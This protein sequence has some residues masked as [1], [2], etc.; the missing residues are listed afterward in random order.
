[1]MI[2]LTWHTRLVSSGKRRWGDSNFLPDFGCGG[3]VVKNDSK[4]HFPEISM[5]QNFPKNNQGLSG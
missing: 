3:E 1:M 4:P 2:E 5:P